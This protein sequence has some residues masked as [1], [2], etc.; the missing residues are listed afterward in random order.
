MTVGQLFD[1]AIENL[2]AQQRDSAAEQVGNGE[3][4]A[5]SDTETK[6]LGENESNDAIFSPKL[7]QNNA[8]V[9]F[10]GRG[11]SSASNSNS[12][13]QREKIQIEV[14]I[15]NQSNCDPESDNSQGR[16]GP[17]QPSDSPKSEKNSAEQHLLGRFCLLLFWSVGYWLHLTDFFKRVSPINSCSLIV[18]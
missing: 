1:P 6:L 16:T 10:S 13:A 8:L 11:E 5:K 14:K 9:N 18:K 15:G 17:I 12:Q 4:D 3:I 7:P 2:S